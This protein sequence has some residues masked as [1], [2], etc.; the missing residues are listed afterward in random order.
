[1]RWIMLACLLMAAPAQ[2]Y[3]L[4]NL[5]ADDV[6]TINRGVD[7]L[8]RE[9]TD[10]NGLYRRIQEQLTAQEAAANKEALDRAEAQKQAVVKPLQDEIDKLK[11]ENEKL[12]AAADDAQPKDPAQ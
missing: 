1:M 4:R 6:R 2:A 3:D 10:A 7:K 11:G 9:E 8:P 5:S 12:K